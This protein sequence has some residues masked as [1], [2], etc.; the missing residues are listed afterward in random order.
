MH[1][2]GPILSRR[3]GRSLGVNVVPEKICSFDCVYCEVGKTRSPTVKRAAYAPA[4]RVLAEFSEHYRQ[5]ENRMDVITVTGYGEPTLNTEFEAVADGIKEIAHHPVVLLTNTSTIHIPEVAQTLKKFDVVVPS[6][7]SVVEEKFKAV[8]RPHPS[9]DLKVLKEALIDF[10]RNYTGKLLIELLLV[11][12]VNDSE[13]DL[14][15][16]ADFIK[17]VNY[18]Q[19]HLMTVYRPPSY[20][21]VRRLSDEELAEKYV[22]LSSCGVERVVIPGVACSAAD[23]YTLELSEDDICEALRMRPMSVSDLAEGLAIDLLL[24]EVMVE[25]LLSRGK[26]SS[27]EYENEI[28]YSLRK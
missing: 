12:E 14:A 4:D 26:L 11:K 19:I 8:D 2:F 3:F 24:A 17:K 27:S 16:F 6:L 15:V 10:S 25:N 7:D 21:E 18:S 5:A 1:I 9:V 20:S 13:A 28:Y 22:F 23:N